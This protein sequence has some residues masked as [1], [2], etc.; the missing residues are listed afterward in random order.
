MKTIFI[1]FVLLSTL[2]LYAQDNN[3]TV[4]IDTNV[5]KQ[6]VA[7][8]TNNTVDINTTTT[9][10]KIVQIKPIILH[11]NI[12][13]Q[14]DEILIKGKAS[15]NLSVDIVFLHDGNEKITVQTRS[16]NDGTWEVKRSDISKQLDDGDYD[17][18]VS[19]IDIMDNKSEITTK[20]GLHRDRT[21]HGDIQLLDGSSL[22]DKDGII[23]LQELQ[24]AYIAGN[25]DTDSVIKRISIYEKEHIKNSI[26][27]DP[28]TVSINNDGNFTIRNIKT[29]LQ[30]LPDGIIVIKLVATD[31]NN[32]LLSVSNEIQKDT[33]PPKPPVVLEKVKNDNMIY[34]KVPNLL[35]FSG[36]AEV[37]STIEAILFN[38]KYP[39]LKTMAKTKTPPSGKWTFSG[40]DFDI[41][42]L[43]DGM[44]QADLIQIDKAG[45]KSE[46]ITVMTKK[47]R[48]PVF[49][50]KVVPIPPE[51]YMPIYTIKDI[52][53]KVKSVIVSDKYIIAGSFE[54]LY[55]FDKTH[56]KL[57]QQIEI[58]NQWVNCLVMS[59]NK[60]FVGLSNG[61]IQIRD[62]NSGKLL[63]TIDA[64]T[65]PILS[66]QVDKKENS[67]ISSSASGD[68]IIFDLSTYKTKYILKK[69]QWDVA[70]IALKGDKLYTGSDD[71]SIKIWD[72]KTGKLL[73]NLKSA[74]GGA[75]NALAIYKNM[76]ISASDDK[77]IFIRDID[78]GKLLHILK[79]HKKAVTALK[80][81]HDVLISAS[82]DRT[83]IL[84]SLK[85]F[86]KIKQL[87]GHSKSILSMDIND[88]NIVTGSLDYRIR[89]WGY[90][91]SLQGQGEIDETVLAKYD[92]VRSLNISN[93]TITA[94]AQTPN[95]L[96][97]ST[98]GYIFFYNNITYKFTRSYST[99]DKVFAVKKDKKAQASDDEEWGDD[100]AE[101]NQETESSDD[102]WSDSE[103]DDESDQP[104]WE[105]ILQKKKEDMDKAAK[106]NLQWV[107]DINLQGVT[108][109]AALGYK[110]IKIWDLER[111]RAIALL[112]GHESSVLSVLRTEGKLISTSADG[113]IKVWD[114]ET[115][116][117]LLSID[118]HQWD[119][120]TVAVDDGKIYSGSDDY[121]IKVWD[122]ETGDLLQTIKNAHNGAITKLLISNKYLIS[123]STDGTIIYR[124]KITGEVI[125]T[126]TDHTASVNTMIMDD[127]HLVSGSDDKT[128]KVW[129]LQSGKLI[130][131]LKNG[132]TDGVTAL[133]ITDDY[134]ISGGKDKKISIWKYYE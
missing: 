16:H 56:G 100:T 32:N 118:A 68:V 11:T 13:A 6:T 117:L 61:K 87:R 128:V 89:V 39:K 104:A 29:D 43:K 82:N 66:L 101:D 112:E 88:E 113:A 5:T 28:A 90:D 116:A 92:L 18:F 14:K 34:G 60:L 40:R 21:I 122:I 49:P 94:F 121:S 9:I 10:P 95:E 31:K 35:V 83:V 20:K 74:Q 77:T 1:V 59:D 114:M 58:K 26:N 79:G 80:I 2:V 93:D 84:W 27:I 65:M 91:E 98:K 52:D 25:I 134:I 4:A 106:S 102:G 75:I 78:T 22:A 109:I 51:D 71:Y 76:L 105:E 48:P 55:Y 132:H 107:N 126:L 47:E 45:N 63:Q 70:A 124:D 110:N 120:R 72:I 7:T 130:K 111:N 17:I 131:T 50:K 8:D 37:D 12:N 23:N 86:E 73:K 67:L 41:V 33:I 81:N 62:V 96:V 44:I 54:F 85:T 57:Q 30:S 3:T 108:L 103:G 19:T 125:R 133:M 38:T 42:N 123:S 115:N 24:T 53:D 127:Q 69:H 99:L 36:S 119:V 129:D 15:P 64:H 46:I 97:F